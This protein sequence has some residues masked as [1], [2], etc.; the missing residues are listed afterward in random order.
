MRQLPLHRLPDERRDRR[1]PHRKRRTAM[2]DGHAR[3][4]GDLRP[5]L[6]GL[7][8]DDR[9][10]AK[11]PGVVCPLFDEMLLRAD[12]HEEQGLS[13]LV[14]ATGDL[15]HR[16]HGC[17]RLACAGRHRKDPAT[18]CLQPR[19]DRRP[20]IVARFEPGRVAGEAKGRARRL[21]ARHGWNVW[22]RGHRSRSEFQKLPASGLRKRVGLDSGHDAIPEP[23]KG[24]PL[25]F[26]TF[27]IGGQP[28]T[29]D[30]DRLKVG[31][32]AT[33]GL[34]R[35]ACKCYELASIVLEDSELLV[36]DADRL[37]C[38]DER[39]PHVQPFV[40]DQPGEALQ[41]CTL[42]VR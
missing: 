33:V 40:C 27:T 38:D 10:D 25:R 9:I 30:I 31:H 32:Q 12:D 34:V 1:D 17:K 35:R 20:L 21:V 14:C 13:L 3:R 39:E 15:E 6:R 4:V 36:V 19:F 5:L 16:S 41:T 22:H 8:A 29:E 11:A 26:G 18:S 28:G 24:D 7:E 42:G 2:V 37:R 23:R